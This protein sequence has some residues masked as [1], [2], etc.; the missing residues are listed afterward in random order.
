[1]GSVSS[2]PFQMKSALWLPNQQSSLPGSE[3]QLTAAL[4]IEA[5]EGRRDQV[6]EGS[7]PQFHLGDAPLPGQ[8]MLCGAHHP[9]MPPSSFGIRAALQ[10]TTVGVRAWPKRSGPRWRVPRSLPM[11]LIVALRAGLPVENLPDAIR[12]EGSGAQ[13]RYWRAILAV[14]PVAPPAERRTT[15]SRTKSSAAA[16]SG[17]SYTRSGS[18]RATRR[19]TSRAAIRRAGSRAEAVSLLLASPEFQRR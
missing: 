8:R 7:V 9:I 5:D 12:A 13:P 17:S 10:A 16:G 14:S 4:A 1:M 15:Q 18:P 3:G 6:H 11:V 19:P 2:N